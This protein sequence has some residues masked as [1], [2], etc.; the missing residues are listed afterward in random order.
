MAKKA[1]AIIV[2]GV[3]INT[4]RTGIWYIRTSISA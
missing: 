4:S 2:A 3:S 1:P